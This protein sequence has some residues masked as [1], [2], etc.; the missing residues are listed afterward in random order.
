M[1]TQVSLS[2]NGFLKTVGLVKPSEYFQQTFLHL[3][4]SSLFINKGKDHSE[5]L[6]VDVRVIL[7]LDHR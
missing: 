3:C 5:E 1:E 2:C 7:K 4:P 6:D